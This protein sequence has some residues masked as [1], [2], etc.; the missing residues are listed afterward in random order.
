[1]ENIDLIDP[2]FAGQPVHRDF[3]NGRA[4]GEVIERPA[5]ARLPVPM[6]LGGLVK[7]RGR[8]RDARHVGIMHQP[9]KRHLIALH[10]N[11]TLLPNHLRGRALMLAGGKLDQALFERACRSLGG[12]AIEIGAR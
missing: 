7:A 3:G 10:R 1:M 6:D 5:A 9:L 4:I 2:V 8:E 12:H 11:T